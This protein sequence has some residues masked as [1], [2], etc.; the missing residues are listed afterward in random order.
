MDLERVRE[1]SEEGEG[2]ATYRD[3][4]RGI[5]LIYNVRGERGAKREEAKDADKAI[6]PGRNANGG[7]GGDVDAFH[8]ASHLREDSKEI[9]MTG[10]GKDEDR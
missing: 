10:V 1:G 7:N 5:I 9:L 8:V 2:D 3:R 6:D 4:E